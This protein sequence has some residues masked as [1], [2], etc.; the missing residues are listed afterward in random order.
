M[1]NFSRRSLIKGAGV[2]GLAGTMGLDGFATAWAQNASWKPEAGASLKLMRWKEFI[3][4][5]GKSFD[6][7]VAAF[8]KATGVAVQVTREGLDDVQP[9]A[10]VAAATGQGPDIVWG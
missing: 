2:A 9:K 1:F 7:I 3:P 5:E 10:S 8:T 6:E 4:S